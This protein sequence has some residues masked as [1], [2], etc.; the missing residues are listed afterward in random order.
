MAETDPDK[1]DD[2]FTELTES[3]NEL[4]DAKAE[5]RRLTWST[6]NASIDFETM[7]AKKGDVEDSFEDSFD[8]EVKKSMIRGYTD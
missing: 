4:A 3:M 8:E 6:M 5:A 7:Q 2:M 1:Y